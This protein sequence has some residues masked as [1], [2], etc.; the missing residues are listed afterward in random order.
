M[1]A[2]D[3][4]GPLG[5]GRMTGRRAGY[6]A[7]YGMPGYMNRPFGFGFR[8]GFGGGGR[9]WRNMYFATG[10]PRWARW[11]AAYPAP[12]PYGEY[13]PEQEIEVLKQQS[14]FFQKQMNMLNQ[15]I[16]ELEEL[17]SN[18]GGSSA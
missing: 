1:P 11:P 13:T 10:L 18:K 8:R 4:T 6:C 14:E 16:R 17:A 12:S 5:Y 9:G 15:R 3:R 2:G 7:G